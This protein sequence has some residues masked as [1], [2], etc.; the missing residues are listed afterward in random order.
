MHI[1]IL[2]NIFLLNI[3]FKIRITSFTRLRRDSIKKVLLQFYMEFKFFICP[4]WDN[5]YQYQFY[6][7]YTFSF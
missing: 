2:Y 5:Y 1:S 4:L 7:Y 6:E 3:R